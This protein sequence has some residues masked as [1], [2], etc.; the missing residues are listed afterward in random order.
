M[1]KARRSPKPR[2]SLL[3]EGV[4][5]TPGKVFDDPQW[6]SFPCIAAG[7]GFFGERLFPDRFIVWQQLP[8]VRQNLFHNVV[9]RLP[10]SKPLQDEHP[11]RDAG[12]V[13][14]GGSGWRK[15]FEFIVGYDGSEHLNGRGQFQLRQH[16]FIFRHEI[17]PDIK[18]A[19]RLVVRARRK[20]C[21]KNSVM[22]IYF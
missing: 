16:T 19:N 1:L 2:R 18:A 10:C 6:Q 20:C 7:S 12:C 17:P 8:A 9:H 4:T 5:N 22:G 11:D 21:A 14:Y 3:N 15:E 13:N